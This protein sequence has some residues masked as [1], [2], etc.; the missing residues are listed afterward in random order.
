MSAGDL[1]VEGVFQQNE[2]AFFVSGLGFYELFAGGVTVFRGS[3]AS[4]STPATIFS[5][6]S[7]GNQLLIVVGGYGYVF[8]LLNNTLSYITDPD[9]PQGYASMCSFLDG[10]GLVLQR[11]TGIFQWSD[12]EDFT[13][14]DALDFAQVSEVSDWTLTLAVDIDRK[15]VRL[16]GSQNTSLYYDS[17]DALQPFIPVPNAL[18]SIGTA[19][20]FGF[21]LIDDVVLWV[22]ASNN[23]ARVA[24]E[25]AGTSGQRISTHAVEAAWA[26]YDV[27][28]D[29][30]GW[31]MSYHGHSWAVFTF[32]TAEATWVYDRTE[33]AWFEWLYWDAVTGTFQ[34]HLVQCHMFAFGQHVGGSR[35]D[36]TLYAI[37][38]DFYDD[39][40]API[41]RMRRFPHLADE[42]EWIFAQGKLQFV[43]QVGVGLSVASTAV[44]YDPKAMLRISRDGGMTYGNA[45][46]TSMGKIGGYTK[47]VN[48]WRNGRFRDGVIEFTFNDPTICA[49]VGANLVEPE[50]GV[51]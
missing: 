32:P 49:L 31:A 46:T 43:L 18:V 41:R 40:G 21:C 30:R 50:E 25:G 51:S 47:R 1:P 9:F 16:I 17:G 23:G 38:G 19:A 45:R 7:G 8:D 39:D 27:V 37:S 34:P 11:G 13:A 20:P 29:C 10:Y 24:M 5:N 33:R 35:L 2:R 4:S 28:S 48:Y 44:G 12:L 3:V 14:W 22:S 15:V 42:E 36:G 26:Q 6:G